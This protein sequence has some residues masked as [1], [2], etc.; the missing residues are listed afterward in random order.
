MLVMTLVVSGACQPMREVPVPNDHLAGTDRV[1]VGP[2]VAAFCGNCHSTPPAG[3]FP[4]ESW[5]LEVSRGYDFYFESFRQDLQ[6]PSKAAVIAYYQSLAPDELSVSPPSPSATQ[7]QLKFQSLSSPRSGIEPPA[8]SFI[9]WTSL[10][11]GEEPRLVFTDM[12]SGE[13]R[14][15]RGGSALEDCELLTTCAHPAHL[16]PCDLDGD[17][18][19]EL[20]LAE[21]GSAQS[22]DHHRGAVIWLRRQNNGWQ[23]RL[24]L[25]GVG[26]VADV[27]PGDFDRD[28]DQDLL[29]AEFGHVR[30][31]CIRLLEN[32]AVVQ[33]VP[34]F[35][36]HVL[37][38]RHGTIHVPVADLNGD[39]H[40]DFVAAISQEYEVVEA[41]LNQGDGT[42][43]REP[44]FDGKD[45]AYGSSG[46]QLVDLDS[47]GDL[48]VVFSNGDTFGSEHLKPYHGIHWLENQGRFPFVHRPLA[49]MVGV[50]K[51][52]AADLDA[53]GDLDIAAVGLMPK[54]LVANPQLQQHDSLIWLE[55]T[56]PGTFIR[57]GLERAQFYHAGLELADVD[58]DGDLDIAV[59]NMVPEDGAPQPWLTLWS[60]QR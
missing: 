25:S 15:I 33:G 56:E 23:Q 39:G 12:R 41:F 11:R 4:K 59:G 51:A 47:D 20:V 30:T 3:S 55:Q 21:L 13:V 26:R 52:L 10:Q 58:R 7:S 34:Q 16:E 8:V 35:V 27:R 45:P 53:D 48:D 17:G 14:A 44:I 40:L 50:Q 32:K 31:G 1:E 46:I 57:H 2:Q 6:P 49:N 37:D 60:N 54:N 5:P 43:R 29:V 18:Q 42:F 9:S 22:G 19:L 36:Q 24:L 28:G 38:H